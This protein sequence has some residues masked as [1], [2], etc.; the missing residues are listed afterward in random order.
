LVVLALF[1]FPFKSIKKTPSFFTQSS[2][3]YNVNAFLTLFG[4]V[5]FYALIAYS[6]LPKPDP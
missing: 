4:A 2:L 1:T 5:T 3:V 6:G